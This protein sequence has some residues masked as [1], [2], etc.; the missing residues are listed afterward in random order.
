MLQDNP[1]P[2]SF[3]SGDFICMGYVDIGKIPNAGAGWAR[4]MTLAMM[5]MLK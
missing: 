3:Q 1:A 4:A 5:V 2:D